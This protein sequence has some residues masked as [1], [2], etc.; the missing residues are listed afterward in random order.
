MVGRTTKSHFS[1]TKSGKLVAVAATSPITR[2][3]KAATASA[4]K[5]QAVNKAGIKKVLHKK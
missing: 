5:M 3:G 2:A 4:K 1:H